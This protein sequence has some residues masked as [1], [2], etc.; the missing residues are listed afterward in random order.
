MTTPVS[1]TLP[2]FNAKPDD[3]LEL[4]QRSAAMGLKG[5]FAFDHLVPI[6]NPARPVFE[7]TTVLGPAAVM[8]PNPV[9]VGSLVL[10]VTLRPPVVTAAIAASVAAITGNRAVIG[11]GVGDRFSVEEAARFGWSFQSLTERLRR[12]GETIEAIRTVAPDLPL[13]IGGTH[14]RLIA[15]ASM[16][17]GWNVWG[18]EPAVLEAVVDEVRAAAG[19]EIVLS[20]GGG[21]LLAETDRQLGDLLAVRGG[22]ATS[23]E[24]LLAGTPAQMAEELSRRAELVDELVVS[25]LPNR[26]EVWELFAD[27]VLTRLD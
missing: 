25:V 5:V 13:W 7:A 1:L 23:G 9:R 12:L 18:A 15:L 26:R 22:R 8:T 27:E 11:L 20:W 21:V 3:F 14:S 17:D 24:R 4:C 19:R 2:Q 10:R 16:V 6:G